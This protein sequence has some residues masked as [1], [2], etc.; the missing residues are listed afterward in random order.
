M[1][2]LKDAAIKSGHGSTIESRQESGMWADAH[3]P[4]GLLR[5]EIQSQILENRILDLI[6]EN[7]EAAAQS[8]IGKMHLAKHW[9]MLKEDDL[10]KYYWRDTFSWLTMRGDERYSAWLD[11][12][13][14]W[15]KQ[16]K[17]WYFP[18]R[19]ELRDIFLESKEIIEQ[20]VCDEYFMGG[21]ESTPYTPEAFTVKLRG[22]VNPF[23]TFERPDVTVDAVI[24]GKSET[25]SENNGRIDPKP[26]HGFVEIK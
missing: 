14:K 11:R 5:N 18:Y 19:F 6:N 17:E 16:M 22:F 4:G 12:C 20:L 1:D 7:P 10:E 3:R 2:Q 8:P 9:W 26:E 21:P 25:Y 23:E 15:F 13:G 24:G